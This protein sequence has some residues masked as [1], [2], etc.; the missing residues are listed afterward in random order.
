MTIA[1][2]RVALR[3]EIGAPETSTGNILDTVMGPGLPRKALHDW[4]AQNLA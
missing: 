1:E 3:R 4:L 2:R